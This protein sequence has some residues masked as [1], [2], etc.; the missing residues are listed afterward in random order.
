VLLNEDLAA[1]ADG[2]QAAIETAIAGIASVLEAWPASHHAAVSAAVRSAVFRDS[3]IAVQF[4]WEPGYDNKVSMVEY[5]DLGDIVC[6]LQVTLQS[7]HA[8]DP[9]LG[10]FSI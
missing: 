10:G 3:P 4:G 5:Q 9:R 8:S 2:E 7:R 6:G 1:F